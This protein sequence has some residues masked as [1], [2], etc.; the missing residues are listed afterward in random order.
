MTMTPLYPCG[1]PCSRGTHDETVK[2]LAQFSSIINGIMMES[3]LRI[4]IR[5]ECSQFFN[6]IDNSIT[7][8]VTIVIDD[9][10]KDGGKEFYQDALRSN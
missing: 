8:T 4:S 5:W 6:L 2:N 3:W 7:F 9:C 1:K 10:A